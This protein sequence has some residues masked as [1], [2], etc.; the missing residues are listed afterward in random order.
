MKCWNC[1]T[2]NQKTARICK[3]CG[4]DLTQSQ[5]DS[6][7]ANES[8]QEKKALPVLWIA[9][10]AAAIVLIVALLIFAINFSSKNNFE[11]AVQATLTAVVLPAGEENAGT[12]GS[13][14]A[15]QAV[16]PAAEQGAGCEYA[17]CAW[18]AEDQCVSCGG[19]WQ[20]YGSE[21][22][23]DCSENK[24]QSQDLEWCRFEGGSWLEKEDRC[25]F[26]GGSTASGQTAYS[27]ACADLYYAK[28]SG[29][30]A[31]YEVYRAACKN[32]G[33]VDQCWDE[34]CNLSVCLCPNEDN[35]PISC[36]WVSGQKVDSN[37]KCYDENG[38]CWL[39]IE[40]TGA[41]GNLSEGEGRLDAIVT[42]SEGKPYS[43]VDLERDASGCIYD[44]NRIS[45]LMTDEGAFNTTTVE[46]IY[47][48]MD[49]CCQNLEKL[50]SGDVVIQ[51]GNC[52]GSGNLEIR[53]FTLIQ[54]V[55]TL[56]ISNSLGW[57]V[58][59][60]E[61][62]LDDAKGDHWTTLTCH[63]DS[64][65]DNVMDCEGWAVY[66]SGFA[67]L[68]FY[69]GSGVNACSVSGVRFQI[70]EMS[71]CNYDQHYCAYT[72]TCCSSGRTCCTCGC[73][74]LDDDETCSDVC[75]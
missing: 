38:T 2:Q 59:A 62:F 73:K 10:G 3:K 47:V 6:Q 68:N 51:S 15:D 53:E 41:F 37:L 8:N 74:R 40:P 33:G 58:G 32:A 26:Q 54:G 17:T 25:T 7:A 24:W 4:S 9:L 31:G 48:C 64:M 11:N 36:D 18:M 14:T 66:K 39:T 1:G 22:F 67:T 30:E 23:C 50:E 5:G 19:T 60:L 75:D 20:T 49:Q 46:N 72:D 65:Y 55:L 12:S 16:S 56:K 44:S 29:D 34:A 42:T 43:S 57:D 45:C 63:T 27:S 28:A 21:S 35:L 70:P 69:Y 71:K 61:V 13:S 52:P